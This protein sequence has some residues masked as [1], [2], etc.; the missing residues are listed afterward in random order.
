MNSFFQYIQ[1]LSDIG[2][3]IEG[4]ANISMIYVAFEFFRGYFKRTV[5]LSVGS[6]KVRRKDFNVQNIT[7]LASLYFF[8]GGIVSDEVRSEIL[9]QTCVKSQIIS[10]TNGADKSDIKQDLSV[11]KNTDN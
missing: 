8:D 6:F 4:V 1:Q 5:K 10:R 3:L 9:S 11:N 2:S 7:N